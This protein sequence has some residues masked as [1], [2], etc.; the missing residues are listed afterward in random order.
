MNGCSVF[1]NQPEISRTRTRIRVIHPQ[2][3]PVLRI[4]DVTHCVDVMFAAIRHGD[5]EVAIP[6]KASVL[7]VDIRTI[8]E[9]R[10]IKPPAKIAHLGVSLLIFPGVNY[11]TRTRKSRRGR[12]IL[13]VILDGQN[14]VVAVAPRQCDK[15]D[16]KVQIA[17]HEIDIAP[18]RRIR[19]EWLLPGIIAGRNLRWRRALGI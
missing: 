18:V 3:S 13:A 6:G 7:V 14:E 10:Q 16:L 4:H 2:R 19:I 8:F 11:I 12:P 1:L 17:I 5:D 15:R 9:N